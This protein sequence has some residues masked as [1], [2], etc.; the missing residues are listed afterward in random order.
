MAA[1]ACE[2]DPWHVALRDNCHKCFT[3][4]L[5]DHV[6]NQMEMKRL[7]GQLVGNWNNEDC[8]MPIFW[9]FTLPVTKRDWERWFWMRMK[10]KEN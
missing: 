2:F 3:M 4:K 9:M 10:T 7:D 5:V 6:A 1:K 8:S